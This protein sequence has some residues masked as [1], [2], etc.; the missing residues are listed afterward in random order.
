MSDD[1]CNDLITDWCSIGD[2]A[3]M[4]IFFFFFFFSDLDALPTIEIPVNNCL[5]S[6]RLKQLRTEPKSQFQK[7][8]ESDGWLLSS[9]CRET[10]A[11]SRKETVSL[12]VSITLRAKW[13]QP[14][15]HVIKKY[16]NNYEYMI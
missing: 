1:V 10:W 16:I 2:R 3:S 8:E 14:S 9:M 11:P 15:T 13:H 12:D 6:P 4:P 7:L 5:V